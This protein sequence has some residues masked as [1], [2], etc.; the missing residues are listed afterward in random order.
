MQCN[1]NIIRLNIHEWISRS[2]WTKP[3]AVTLTFKQYL[4][5]VEGGVQSLSQ[6]A[7]S[8]NV[9]H[10]L[11]IIDK[12]VYGSAAE[13]YGKR[14]MRLAVAEGTETKHLH[15]HLLL[16]CPRPNLIEQYPD[17]ISN[18]WIGTE[19]GNKQID[20]QPCDSGWLDYMTKFRDKPNFAD[21]FDWE[22]CHVVN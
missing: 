21:A 14:V 16:D 15:Y 4:R 7:A 22:N 11:N 3:F 10:F 19:W 2:K 20:I 9:R 5:M 6:S 18:T 13:R 1:R 12:Q 8:R 17:M